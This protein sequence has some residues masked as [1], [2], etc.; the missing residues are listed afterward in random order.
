MTTRKR[1]EANLKVKYRKTLELAFI[2]SLLLH[3][4]LV[5]GF[6]DVDMGARDVEGSK[7]EIH[8][9][10]I[11]VTEQVKRPPAPPRPSIPIPTESEEVP[12]DVT[13]E[14]T[15]IDWDVAQ[16]PPPP[17]ED[18]NDVDDAYMFVP[19]DEP[20]KPIGGMAAIR[21]HLKYPELARKAGVE[22]MVVVGVL[23]D[24][25]GN[26]IKTQVLKP[27]GV[28]IGF[29]EAAQ[30]AVMAVKWKPAKQRDRP[31]K[32]WVS[33]PIRFRLQDVAAQAS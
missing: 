22:G 16:L 11:P 30:A 13:I 33:I 18:G 19:Y 21:R 26:P 1:P 3:L 24:A 10:D 15:E 29:E 32:V 17:P 4:G 6:P 7:V 2:V 27:A 12:E 14:S 25:Q 8:V 23:I 9:E 5:R 20:P 28:D 31:V